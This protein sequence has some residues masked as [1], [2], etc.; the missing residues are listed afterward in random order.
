MPWDFTGVQ[1]GLAILSAQVR[2]LYNGL[3]GAISD[4][5][6]TPAGIFRLINALGLDSSLLGSDPAAPGA[7]ISRIYPKA[8]GWFYRE[9]AAGVATP[10]STPPDSSLLPIKMNAAGAAANTV[11]L[12]T[13]ANTWAFGP[14]TPG[15]FAS[16]A[17]MFKLGQ[18]ELSS[19]AS[20][21]TFSS[22]PQTY[23]NLLLIMDMRTS[24]AAAV[25]T[26]VIRLNGDAGANY[27]R[28]VLAVGN[29]TTTAAASIGTT[30]AEIA[31]VPAAS[32]TANFFGSAV[33]F[34]PAY[35]RAQHKG[36]LAYGGSRDLANVAN[37]GLRL[38]AG[39]WRNVAAITQIDILPTT[40][41]NFV[42][43]CSFYLYGLPG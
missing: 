10:L 43:G 28:Q 14:I 7:G 19:T 24:V 3:T 31:Q 18:A 33:V 37:I 35:T 13:G 20:S 26:V 39:W 23:K 5:P 12:L 6:I 2:Q 15:Y 41:P 11:L 22:I 30:V 27:D 4:Q 1:P 42:S 9:G 34:F 21:V 38:Y 36:F 8:G 32:A 40:G 25:D 16:G 17:A 29:A